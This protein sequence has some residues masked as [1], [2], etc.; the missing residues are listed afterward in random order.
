MLDGIQP[1]DFPFEVE[2]YAAKEAAKRLLTRLETPFEHGWALTFEQPV[3][4]AGL[5][6]LQD[7]GVWAKWTA[8]PEAKNLDEL[9]ALAD[10]PC[11]RNLLR[12]FRRHI[13]AL[14]LLEEVDVD[15][16]KPTPYSLSLGDAEAYGDQI[17]KCG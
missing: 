12:R 13:A 16:W 4:V 15:T 8:D 3:L 1:S 9:L 5:K 10:V 14:Y 17:I 11:E 2:R 6:L 7:L